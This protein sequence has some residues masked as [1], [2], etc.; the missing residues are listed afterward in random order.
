MTQVG[1]GTVYDFWQHL[2]NTALVSVPLM[3]GFSS[4]CIDQGISRAYPFLPTSHL[5]CMAEQA[6]WGFGYAVLMI[7]AGIMAILGLRRYRCDRPEVIKESARILLLLAGILTII[8][9]IRGGASTG[10]TWG[11]SRYLICTWVSIPALL[12]PLWRLPWRSARF[13]SFA[14]LFI[15]LAHSMVMTFAVIS[16]ARVENTQMYTFASYLEKKHITRFYS[17]YWT[18][19][20]II[21]YTQE[22]L[23]CGN[24]DVTPHNRLVHG[25]DRYKPYLQVLLDAKDPAFVYPST[26]ITIG[27]VEYYLKKKGISYTVHE[28]DGYTIIAPKES[29][30]S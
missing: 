4:S 27:V 12:W 14:L 19:N 21:F 24:T 5:H 1:Q 23:I 2:L 20:R 7:V 16:N 15:V 18:C 8:L 29:V 13:A 3:T 17:D 22:K 25:Y 10:D 9:Y 30:L 26:N 28:A 6:M 11:A